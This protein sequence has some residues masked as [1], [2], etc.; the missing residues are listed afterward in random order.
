M[1]PPGDDSIR[2][3]PL[4][5]LSGDAL[6]RALAAWLVFGGG[7]A[8]GEWLAA[9]F[10]ARQPEARRARLADGFRARWPDCDHVLI[11]TALTSSDPSVRAAGLRCTGSSRYVALLGEA[12]LGRDPGLCDL[13]ADALARAGCARA[14]RFISARILDEA[15]PMRL[16]AL[17]TKLRSIPGAEVD[18]VLRHHLSHR[19]GD[20]RLAALHG[21]RDRT[22]AGDAARTARFDDD[23]RVRVLAVSMLEHAED[24]LPLQADTDPTVRRLVAHALGHARRA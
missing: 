16:A 22:F 6:D 15:D 24:L 12:L 8:Q 7:P 14:G 3:A 20:V 5:D 2:D 4:E 1:S 9:C 11:R 21:C 19:H 23:A 10:D 13:A 17:L 18:G